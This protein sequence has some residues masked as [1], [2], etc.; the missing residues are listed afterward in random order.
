MKTTLCQAAW[1]AAKAKGSRL[2]SFS[3]RIVNREGSL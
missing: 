1:V 3:H 2:S